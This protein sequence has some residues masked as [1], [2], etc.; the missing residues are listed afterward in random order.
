MG[1]GPSNPAK[2]ATQKPDNSASPPFENFDL[3]AR[4]R[5][6]PSFQVAT[7]RPRSDLLR[8]AYHGVWSMAS[9][10][11]NPPISRTGQCSVIDTEHDRLIIAYGSDASGACLNDAWVLD[12][13]G[14]EWTCLAPSLLGPRKY[15]SAVLVNR[16][17]FIFGGVCESTFFTDLHFIDIDTGSVTRVETSGDGPCARTSPV[18]FFSDDRLMVWGG[19]GDHIQNQLHWINID[20]GEWHSCD[21]KQAGRPAAAFCAH[22]DKEFVFGSSSDAGLLRFD[23]ESMQF[24]ELSPVGAG[25]LPELCHPALVAADEYLFVV[26]GEAESGYMDLFALDVRRLRWFAFHV[27]PDNVSL[28]VADGTVSN[29]GLFMMPRESSASVAYNAHERELVSVMGS[30][31][32]D[33]APVFRI[34]IGEALG[35]LHLRSDMYDMFLSDMESI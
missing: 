30:L 27:R 15:P 21:E 12:L 11:G 17:M 16:K 26:G 24:D 9:T 33:P 6:N 25:P 23:S 14:L 29:Q 13:K 3:S 5:N 34:S 28:T 35:V 18:F 2:P 32:M 4:R 1:T 19:E 10:H 22:G 20:G 31:I 8:T 7:K